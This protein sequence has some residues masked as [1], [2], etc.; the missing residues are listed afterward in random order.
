METVVV[1]QLYRALLEVQNVVELHWTRWTTS[2]GLVVCTH[3]LGKVH[4]L[5]GREKAWL[6]W[7][8]MKAFDGAVDHQLSE[9]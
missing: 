6:N 1:E 4:K 7:S 5:F 2:I 9:N 3:V 8:L